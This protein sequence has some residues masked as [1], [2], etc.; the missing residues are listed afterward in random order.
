[1]SKRY[2]RYFYNPFNLKGIMGNDNI[3]NMKVKKETLDKARGIHFGCRL[4]D[5]KIL[6]VLVSFCL[7]CPKEFEEWKK[8]NKQNLK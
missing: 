1:M 6:N 4:C 7:D 5:W 8:K 2:D 3:Q